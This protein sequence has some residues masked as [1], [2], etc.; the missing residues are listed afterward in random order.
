MNP[1]DEVQILRGIYKGA[2]GV[3]EH[4]YKPTSHSSHMAVVTWD[5]IKIAID[6]WDIALVSNEEEE[7]NEAD[8]T[9]TGDMRSADS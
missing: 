7:L 8:T 1:G 5:G 2:V 9:A 6:P 4:Y 3:L